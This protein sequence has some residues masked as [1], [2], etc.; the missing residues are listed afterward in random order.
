MNTS[1]LQVHI[2][3]E[4]IIYDLRSIYPFKFFS[5]NFSLQI[6]ELSW[7]YLSRKW[8]AEG[9][10]LGYMILDGQRINSGINRQEQWAEI[11]QQEKILATVSLFF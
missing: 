4:G 3:G 1:N 6:I 9:C 10:Y 5:Q 8:F 7:A 11:T 2:F